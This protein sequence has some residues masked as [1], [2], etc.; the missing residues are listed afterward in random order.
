MADEKKKG[1]LDKAIDALTDRDEKA[2]AAEK[3]KM[4]LEA[5]AKAAKAAEDAKKAAASVNDAAAKIAANQAAKAKAEAEAQKKALADQALR[6]QAARDAL[7][8][9][10]AADR[11]AEQA[12][13]LKMHTITPNETLSGL[14]LHFYGHATPEY[15]NLIIQ[16]NK[17]ELGEDIKN[18]KPGKTIKIPKLPDS[19]KK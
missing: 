11:A 8:A 7:K 15:W 9:K 13:I 12:K 4:E 2:A 16:A 14:A 3:A 19:M 5:K 10:E 6:E 18:Y 17:A 1:I